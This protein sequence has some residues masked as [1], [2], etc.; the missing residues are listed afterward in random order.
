[1]NYQNII[2]EINHL[3][4][5]LN[6]YKNTKHN[7]KQ[8]SK[9]TTILNNENIDT[10]TI[11]QIKQSFNLDLYSKEDFGTLDEH[12]KIDD[13]TK[14]DDIRGKIDNIA[15]ELRYFTIR[16]IKQYEINAKTIDKILSTYSTTGDTKL[17]NNYIKISDINSIVLNL[18]AIAELFD[19]TD[20]QK[21]YDKIKDT[22]NED[23]KL[24]ELF[25]DK[26][27]ESFKSVG[28]EFNDEENIIVINNVTSSRDGD[29]TFKSLGYSIDNFNKIRDNIYTLNKLIIRKSED[30][31]N[32]IGD[33][34]NIED[35]L[36]S[37]I[38]KFI[39]VNIRFVSL[40][41]FYENYFFKLI[42]SLVDDL[43]E[44]K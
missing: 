12:L 35:A 18:N 39:S 36:Q 33:I 22:Y 14:L 15:T 1:M 41:L 37:F 3:S 29:G 24:R 42:T 20:I 17:D 25:C 27:L 19:N 13:K 43:Q 8:L 6:D 26:T 2:N 16:N 44:G 21:S 30:F 11:R 31:M 28:F 23:T 34:D 40:C 4:L 5:L 9:L 38:S 7:R 10:R 32:T